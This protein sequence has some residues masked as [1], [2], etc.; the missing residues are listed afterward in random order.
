VSSDQRRGRG[1]GEGS[2][3]RGATNSQ[4]RAANRVREGQGIGGAVK[5]GVIGYM[6][7]VEAV[8]AGTDEKEQKRKGSVLP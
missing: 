8:M 3:A 4:A 2:V 1:P 7:E 5:R 6:C